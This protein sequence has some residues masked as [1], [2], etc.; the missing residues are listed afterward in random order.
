MVYRARHKMNMPAS[1]HRISSFGSDKYRMLERTC[2]ERPCCWRFWSLTTMVL[3]VCF[4]RSCSGLL[5]YLC[6]E[7]SY[8]AVWI[9]V[10]FLVAGKRHCTTLCKHFLNQNSLGK[11]WSPTGPMIL[12]M[13]N[14]AQSITKSRR[15]YALI[16]GIS[17]KLKDIIIEPIARS[18]QMLIF[19][20]FTYHENTDS[21][22]GLEILT[23]ES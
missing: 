6:F 8:R 12:N 10:W 17:Y 3:P 16:Q 4:H 7:K 22:G 21:R 1:G 13:P 23:E 11:N 5:P 9:Y 14:N 19:R 20:S 18:S 15:V 2:A